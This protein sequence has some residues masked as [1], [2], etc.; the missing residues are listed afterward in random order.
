MTSEKRHD[1]RLDVLWQGFITTE[2][3]TKYPCKV[4]DIAEGGALI[5][6]DTQGLSLNGD[7]LLTIDQ[8]G[9]FAGRVQWQGSE[10]FGLWLLAGDDLALKKFAEKAGSALSSAPEKAEMAP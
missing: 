9:E 8:L 2:D 1:E 4:R 10:K 5:S 7:I 3:G 6:C